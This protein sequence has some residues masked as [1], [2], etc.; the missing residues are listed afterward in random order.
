MAQIGEG[1]EDQKPRFARLRKEHFLETITLEE[2]LDLFKL[3]RQIGEYEDKV[4]T[5]GVGRF[6]PYV[7]HDSK[8]YSLKKGVDDPME[9]TNERAIELITE[10]READKK[11]VIQVF[12]GEEDFRILRGRYGPYISFKSK[13]YRI[14]KAT[15][16]E[17]LSKDDCLEIIKKADAK[18][19][20]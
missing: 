7:R 2:A 1:G 6:G 16:P 20:K 11:K 8:F 5:V 14:P 13:N 17:K 19:K 4:L 12:E 15:E 10:K 3:P 18:A 9:I